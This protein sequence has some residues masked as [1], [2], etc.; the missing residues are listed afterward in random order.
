MRSMLV[1]L[2]ICSVSLSG[3]GTFSDAF[4]GPIDDHVYYRGVRLDVAAVKGGGAMTL[5][6]ADLPLSAVADSLLLPLLL[7]ADMT[8]PPRPSLR[9]IE[10]QT[11]AN[12]LKPD[13]ALQA[14]PG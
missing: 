2:A 12:L 4:C 14:K 9:A 3:C 7:Y 8:Q 5:M 13:P 10:E 11:N 1:I 6:A